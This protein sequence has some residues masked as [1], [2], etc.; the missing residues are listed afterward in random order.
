MKSKVVGVGLCGGLSCGVRSRA[1][2]CDTVAL[3]G[4]GGGGVVRNK[5]VMVVVVNKVVGYGV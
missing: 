1:V 2:V 5:A 4:G 3:K